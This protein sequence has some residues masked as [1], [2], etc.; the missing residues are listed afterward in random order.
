MPWLAGKFGNAK[1]VAAMSR[2]FADTI[3]FDPLGAASHPLRTAKRMWQEGS[4]A[5][6]VEFLNEPL[7][8]G[9]QSGVLGRAWTDGDA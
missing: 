8:A 7:V 9:F 6:L 2:A 3:G 4:L 1:A 5:P